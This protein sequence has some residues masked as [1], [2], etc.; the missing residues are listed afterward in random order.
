MVNQGKRGE[1]MRRYVCL[2]E[3]I[4]AQRKRGEGIWRYVCLKKKKRAQGERGLR[5]GNREWM[6]RNGVEVWGQVDAIRC[7][8]GIARST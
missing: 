2:S 5:I 3:K 8:G 7:L 6:F 4:G 1:G